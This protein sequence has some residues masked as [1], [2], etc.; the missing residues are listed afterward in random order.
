MKV[1]VQ[2][3]KKSKSRSSEQNAEQP[4]S[5]RVAQ[6]EAGV[7]DA[8]KTEV[9]RLFRIPRRPKNPD[10]SFL[11][12]QLPTDLT[13][14][15]DEELGRIH[16][17]FACMARYAQLVIAVKAVEAAKV[18]RGD[19][20][21]RARVRLEKSGTNPD[22]DAKTEIDPRTRQSAV[23]V[24]IGEGVESMSKAMLEGY[25]IG[26]DACSREQTRRQWM[27]GLGRRS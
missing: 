23:E 13:L 3:T 10:G 11:D 26:R 5:K 12:P 17:E 9:K 16:S 6:L 14:V 25:L 4:L 27:T 1:I 21:I 18:K 20:V 7:E 19:K 2:K 8:V 22:K 15:E 24:L